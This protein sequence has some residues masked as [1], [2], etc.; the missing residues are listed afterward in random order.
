[1]DPD[2]AGREECL[3]VQDGPIDM[4]FGGEVDDRV[5]GID[6]RAHHRRIGDVAANEAKARRQLLVVADRREI[7]LIA[8]V[9]QLVEHGDVCPIAPA[10][11]VPDIRGTDEARTAGHQQMPQGPG[12]AHPDQPT[13]RVTGGARRPAAS[14]AAAS[15]AARSNDGTVP[16]S[17]QCPS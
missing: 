8:C 17:A 7:G 16:A 4:R 9:G 11:H 15:S 12:L 5:G 13:G 6:E 14:S 3:R 10:Q 2:D 1:M